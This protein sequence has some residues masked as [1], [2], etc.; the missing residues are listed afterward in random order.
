MK[1]STYILDY[2]VNQEQQLNNVVLDLLHLA[3]YRFREDLKH[4]EGE[5]L[6][7][8]SITGEAVN[9]CGNLKMVNGVLCVLKELY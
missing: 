3:K 7:I 2:L 9:G 4:S 1:V 8:I 6:Y 5:P